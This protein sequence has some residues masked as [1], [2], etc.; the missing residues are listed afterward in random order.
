MYHMTIICAELGRMFDAWGLDCHET[1][2][3]E[4]CAVSLL[5]LN[6]ELLYTSVYALMY[7]HYIACSGPGMMKCSIRQLI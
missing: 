6:Y 5:H 4:F 7:I 1:K 2:E 3:A